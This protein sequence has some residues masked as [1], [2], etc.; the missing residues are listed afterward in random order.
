MRNLDESFRPVPGGGVTSAAPARLLG[1]RVRCPGGGTMRM[2]IGDGYAQRV[3]E[4]R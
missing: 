1:R 3:P 2:Y 4:M